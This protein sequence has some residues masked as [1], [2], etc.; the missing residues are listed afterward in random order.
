MKKKRAMI[1]VVAIILLLLVAVA[2]V[3]AAYVWFK[4]LQS[5]I[6]SGVE[7]QSQRTIESF[8]IDLKIFTSSY[9]AGE[10]ILW[11]KNDGTTIV[12][13]DQESILNIKDFNNKDICTYK[14]GEFTSQILGINPGASEKLAINIGQK[15]S[16][17]QG[18][19]V[20]QLGFKDG[21]SSGSF[22]VS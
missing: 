16:L 2:L 5:N 18:D 22:R 14:V 6:Q 15:C 7:T 9:S 4:G 10:L 8:N 13:I 19:Y 20:V 12:T 1:E 21:L 11:L 17:Q 3:G